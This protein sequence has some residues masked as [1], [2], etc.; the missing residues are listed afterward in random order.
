M[1]REYFVVDSEGF[2]STTAVTHRDGAEPEAF[3]SLKDARARACK[4][5]MSEPGR[6]VVITRAVAY[7]TCPVLKPTVE[8]RKL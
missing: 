7:V 3:A 8:I 6:T 4:L 5:A 1:T 2:I